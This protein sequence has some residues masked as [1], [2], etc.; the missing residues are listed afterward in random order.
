MN[1]IKELQ[2]TVRVLLGNRDDET[3]VGFHH[4]LL[5]DSCFAFALLHLIDD[6]AEFT[7]GNRGFGRQHLDFRTQ[8]V[9]GT[10]F[11]GCKFLPATG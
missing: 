5:G 11:L 1:E 2:A 7:D 4:F 6:A 10:L 8:T 3:K 9:D